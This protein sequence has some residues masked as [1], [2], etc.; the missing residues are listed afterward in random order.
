MRKVE[1][2]D[3]IKLNINHINLSLQSFASKKEY[4]TLLSYGKNVQC[5]YNQLYKCK[6]LK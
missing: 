1:I 4:I 3:K 6:K 2:V 5:Y